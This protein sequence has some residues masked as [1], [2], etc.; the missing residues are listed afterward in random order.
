MESAKSQHAT[1]AKEAIA[2]KE[3]ALAKERKI[4]M[5]HVKKRKRAKQDIGRRR[6]LAAWRP[7]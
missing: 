3:D 5:Q 6:F 2:V 1:A 7:L 4:E